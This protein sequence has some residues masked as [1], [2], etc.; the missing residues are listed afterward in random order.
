[1]SL[2]TYQLLTAC[3]AFGAAVFWGLSTVIHLDPWVVPEKG[4]RVMELVAND[5]KPK[6]W[7]GA[8]K[9]Q[10]NL[11]AIA[12]ALSGVAALMSATQVFIWPPS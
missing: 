8:L 11:N 10:S 6:Q 12:A 4:S 7:Y 2:Y 9:R 1:M 5:M 3:F